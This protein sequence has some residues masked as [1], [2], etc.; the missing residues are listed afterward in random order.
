MPPHLRF[1]VS[2][3]VIECLAEIVTTWLGSIEGETQTGSYVFVGTDNTS[4]VR[5]TCKSNFSESQAPHSLLAMKLASLVMDS[6][7]CMHSQHFAGSL[8]VIA[9]SLSR[10][11]SFE[12]RLFD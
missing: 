11:F 6:D 7:L 3:N 12:R 5:Y 9:N 1:S 8:S 2:S 4:V 10:V